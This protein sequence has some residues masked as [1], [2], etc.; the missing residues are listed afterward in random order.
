[1]VVTCYATT[2]YYKVTCNDYDGILT[3]C[4]RASRLDAMRDA[5]SYLIRYSYIQL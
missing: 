1:M 3:T 2:M 5:G 4:L